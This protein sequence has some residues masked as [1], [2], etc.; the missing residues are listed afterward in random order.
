VLAGEM[1]FVGPR[2]LLP[3]TVVRCGA[4]G[5]VRGF[6]RPGLTGWAQVNGNARLTDEDKLALDIWYVDHRGPLLDLRILI[7]TVGVV[8]LGERVRHDRLVAAKAHLAAR[9]GGAP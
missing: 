9:A 8:L 5:H 3:E 2:P 6:V 4:L 7:E 1:A